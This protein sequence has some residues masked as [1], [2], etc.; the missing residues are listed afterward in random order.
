[1]VIVTNDEY[2]DAIRAC[3]LKP[4]T[5][6][7]YLN[8]L[9]TIIRHVN[10][11]VGMGSAGAGAVTLD[12][13]LRNADKYYPVIVREATALRNK[14]IQ[15]HG[16]GWLKKG[17]ADAQSTIRSQVK[18]LIALMKYCGI[19]ENEPQ[20]YGAW[21][22]YF[23]QLNKV[24]AE[25][26]DNNLP[27]D[28]TDM[29]WEEIV[30]RRDLFKSGSVEHVTL[31]LYTYIPPRRQTDYFRLARSKAIYDCKP[32][33]NTGWLDTDVGRLKVTQFKTR[34]IYSDFE[35]DIPAPLLASIKL[36][37]KDRDARGKAKGQQRKQQFLFTKLNGEPYPSVSSF[38]DANNNVL[39]RTLGNEHACVNTI[40]H[41]AASHV[42]TSTT[43]LRGE[44]KRWALAMGHS[45]AMQGHYVIARI[46]DPNEKK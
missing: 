20:V 46:E 2:M 4:S 15:Q 10:V 7:S 42:A 13:V 41:A 36:F 40:R 37:L 3:G 32:D 31:G 24:M 19:K 9:N 33:E 6:K 30:A 23:D 45:L 12:T 18:T 5:I 39:K 17:P 11:G 21:Y 38:T 28:A 44:K 14:R 22:K 35:C 25:R 8:N 1:M 34:D 16:G 27:T 43:M 29:M 26:E